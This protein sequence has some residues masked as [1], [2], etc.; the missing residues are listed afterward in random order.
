[1]ATAGEG[2]TYSFPISWGVAYVN[3]QCG[4]VWSATVPLDIVAMGFYSLKTSNVPSEY[5]RTK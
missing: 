1:M 5:F 2:I 3:L 4:N